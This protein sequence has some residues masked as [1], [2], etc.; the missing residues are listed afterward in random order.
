MAVTAGGELAFEAPGYRDALCG[1]IGASVN[2]VRDDVASG[3][4]PHFPHGSVVIKPA[5]EELPR[6]EIALLW[7]L[8]TKEWDFWRPGEDTFADLT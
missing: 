8:D 7:F 2:A 3:L 5:L 1:F 6:P 4:Q